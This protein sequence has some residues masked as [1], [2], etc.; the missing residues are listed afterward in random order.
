MVCCILGEIANCKGLRSKGDFA[1]DN[2]VKLH[3]TAVA[4]CQGA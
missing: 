3:G 4:S 1:V 2:G